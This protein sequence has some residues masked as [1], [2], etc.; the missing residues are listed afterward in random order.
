MK[1]V[2]MVFFPIPEG[3]TLQAVA[4]AKTDVIVQVFLQWADFTYF[5]GEPICT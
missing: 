4:L 1:S 2:D 3:I 5:A